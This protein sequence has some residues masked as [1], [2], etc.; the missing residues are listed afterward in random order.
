VLSLPLELYH[1]P[2]CQR[3]CLTVWTRRARVHSH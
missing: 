1:Q 3:N 2:L